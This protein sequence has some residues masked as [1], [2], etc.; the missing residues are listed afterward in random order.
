MGRVDARPKSGTA[1]T[2]A[3]NAF[4]G[5][6]AAIRPS[7]AKDRHRIAHEGGAQDESAQ[8]CRRRSGQGK[9]DRPGKR[10]PKQD[11]RLA[12][13]QACAD[14]LV[15]LAVVELFMFRISD[16]DWLQALIETAEQRREQASGPIHPR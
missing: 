1:T 12:L 5:K 3:G 14:K 2:H 4:N 10:F 6:Y 7:G 8:P 16:H 11:K 15:K 13:W 9:R